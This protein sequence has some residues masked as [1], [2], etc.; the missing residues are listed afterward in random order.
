MKRTFVFIF[1]CLLALCM[2][3]N[4]HYVVQHYSILDGMSQNTVMAILQDKQGFMWFGTWDGLNRF[5]GYTFEVFKAMSHGEAAH[6]NNRVDWIYEDEQEQIWW[7]TYDGHYYC[8]DATRKVTTEHPY[9]SIPEGMIAKMNE[10]EKNTK[11]DSRGI[12]WQADNITGIQ[13]YRYGQWKRF[14]PPLDS[15]YAG[16]LREHFLLLEDN[17]GRTWVNPTGGGWSYYD[18]DK[19]ELV[20][21]IEG[22]TN[23]IHTAYIDHDG[24]MWIATYD[25]G[26]DCVN[27]DPTPYQLHDMRRSD[28]DNGE[29]R[30][31]A[32]TKKGEV[33]TLVK[34]ATNVYCALESRHGLL[35]GT[36]G[37]GLKWKEESGKWRVVPTSHPDIY[38]IEEG[39]DGTLYVATYGDGVNIIRWN[40]SGWSKPEVI[41]QGMKVRDIEIVGDDLWCGTTTGI[42]RIHL[43]T[44]ESTVIPS[45]DI[46]AIYYDKDRLWFGSFGGGLMTLLLTD[47]K[48]EIIR[49]ETFHDI[50]LSLT[51]DGHNLW[52]CSESDI[53]QLDLETGNL[54]Y[55]DALDGEKNT[56]FTEAEALR[57]PEG[58][59][60]FGYTNGYCSFDPARISRSNSVPPL[61]ITRVVSQDTELTGDSITIADGSN[62]TIEYA[63]MEYVGTNKIYYS[64]KM[65]GVDKNWN[66]P[67]DL[68]RVTYTN[69]RHGSYVFH[70]R[71]TNREGGDVDNEKMLYIYVKSPLWLSWWAILL[72]IL[73]VALL[74]AIIA[75]F[76]GMYNSLRQKVK[77][78]QQVTDIKL[79]FF[80]NI[81]H[82]LRTPLT[83]IAAPVDNILQHERISQ[84]VRSQLEIVQSN[85]Q[86][87][88]RMVNQLLEFRKVQNQKMKLK[89][90]QT[91]LSE[92]VEETC[93]N[94]RKEADDKHIRFEIENRAEDSTVW[95]DRARMDTILWNLLSN[96]FK[97]TPAGKAIRVIVDTKPGFVTLTVQDEGIGIPPEKQ[98][99]LFERFSSNNELNNNNTGG[100]GIGMNL[101]KEL[102]D[103]H[104]G[105]IEVESAVGVG[106][107]ITVLLHTGKEHFDADV[108]FI[109]MPSSAMPVVT[110]TF[111]DKIEQL[112]IEQQESQHT[113]LVVDDSKDMRTFLANIFSRE[114]HVET[115][116][117]GEEAE[118]I[119]RTKPIDLVITDL[120]MPKVD[121][122]ELTQFIKKNK[123]LDYIPV[124][125]LTAK[126]AI[127]SKLEALEYGADDYVTK[128]FEPEY[129]RARVHN[130]LTQR[131][132]LEQ[133]YRQ[134]LMR[135]EPQKSDEPIPGDAFLAKLLDVMDKQLDNNTLTVDD[136]VDEMGMGRTVFFNKLK[137]MTGLSPVEFIR[138]MRIKRAAQLLEERQYN[139]TEVTYMV[140][141]NDSRYFAKCFK[142]TYGI[143]PSE[144]R[145]A[146]LEK[147]ER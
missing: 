90:Q 31:F 103:L 60:L 33:L 85:S 57:T 54:Y 26:V 105:H 65:D 127:E 62:V 147:S 56:Y 108:D 98:N 87:M 37:Q 50:I 133:S 19:D 75:Y 102:V 120:M 106:T 78:E 25:G 81:S 99:V 10:S 97:F 64:Y 39:E 67:T 100:T 136:L 21:P 41:G 29:V 112:Q 12:I 95:I 119:I 110:P 104:H 76:L 66:P 17:L 20:Y 145:K 46:R 18:Y 116:A 23:M 134:R 8:L 38:D 114:Y 27:M 146:A 71:S 143:T 6:V 96:A 126:T 24:Q 72:Y 118:R 63:A 9:D 115:A 121:G 132:Q 15:R 86:R 88:L 68:R 61:R 70:V 137:S 42:L 69:L 135:L 59:I 138:E 11:V 2:S 129:L 13:R 92:L 113:V 51:G 140:G 83:L 101:T 14:T 123:D 30:A 124:I 131:E 84:N 91:L 74:I 16:R 73:G 93:A 125:L 1:S 44:K 4:E 48:M 58:K 117:D 52:F 34:S 122:L 107:T 53:A 142:N 128:P 40:G 49:V 89:V 36:K 32:L 47:P 144:Y 109:D 28:K 82:E 139:I 130:I 22:L 77:V 80:T 111:E 55:Y 79:R 5:D 3:A 141:M 35:Y 7:S 45:Y 43:G 94:F